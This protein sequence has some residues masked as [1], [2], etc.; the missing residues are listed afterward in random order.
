MLGKGT[1]TAE[2]RTR[3]GEEVI[4]EIPMNG[5]FAPRVIDNSGQGSVTM[6]SAGYKVI[7]REM[8]EWE[9]EI[10]LYRDSYPAMCGP[11]LTVEGPQVTFYDLSY[12][13]N[14][15]VISEDLRFDGDLSDLFV[16]IVE[17]ALV[18]DPSPNIKVLAHASGI[19]QKRHW[20]GS[21]S[22]Y[23]MSMLTELARSALDFTTIGRTIYVGGAE[24]YGEGLDPL[25]IHDGGVRQATVRRDGELFA[26][27]MFVYC[28]NSQGESRNV[29]LVGRA[30]HAVEKS[31]LVQRSVTELQISD[32]DSANQSAE[33]RLRSVQ[34]TPRFLNVTFA[35]EADFTY[36]ELL[37]GRQARVELTEDKCD[38][39]VFATMRIES[40]SPT[41]SGQMETITATLVPLDETEEEFLNA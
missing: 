19:H 38:E 14:R 8:R 4:C 25:I 23:A 27:D 24:I 18:P 2:L 3:G 40:V 22:R 16:Q 37:A 9:H 34:P 11:V 31:G 36:D 10:H 6:S 28:G 30:T 7:R 39:E 12:W 32:L 21:E 1:W 26:T 13:M 5:C 29:P 41:V 20:E 33:S 15:R 17:M 35:P